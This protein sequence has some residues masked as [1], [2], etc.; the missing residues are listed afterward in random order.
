MAD[1]W[2]VLPTTTDGTG[3][4]PKYTDGDGVRAFSGNTLDFS[5]S[6]WDG[7]PIELPFTGEMY[8]VRLFGEADVLD[9]VA[10][11]PDVYTMASL[12]LSG[13]EVADVLNQH[14]QESRSFDEWE[15][16]F[17]EGD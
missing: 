12:G 14:F 6:K 9:S 3:R 16:S 17:R 5:A 1:R 2:F 15:Q 4:R 13:S 7:F 8:V 11:E 10:S